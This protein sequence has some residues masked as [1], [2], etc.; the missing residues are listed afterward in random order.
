MRP[1]VAASPRDRR[2]ARRTFPFIAALALLATLALSAVV[3]AEPGDEPF[4]IERAPA[5]EW[6]FKQSW[7]SYAPQPAVTRGASVVAG[8]E[9]APYQLGWAFESGSYDSAS[10]TTVLR[11]EG[12]AHWLKYP[13][14]SSSI[15]PPPGYSG[16]MDIHVLDVTLSDPV[17]TISRD[18][19]TITVEASSRQLGTWQIEDLGRVPVVSLDVSEAAPAVADGVTTWTAIPAVS[20]GSSNE[21]FAGNYPAGRAVD[22]VGFSYSGP[23]GAPDLSE[24][25]DAPGSTKLAL[26]DN[27]I[28]TEDGIA[29]QFSAWWLDRERRIVHHRSA[30]TVDGAPV[31][32]YRALSLD[33]RAPVG[34]PLVLPNAESIFQ[35]TFFDSDGGRLFYRRSGET[36]TSRWVEFDAGQG[37]YVLGTLSEPV[38]IVGS[39]SLNWDSVA[40][41]A[42]NV[43]RFVPDGVAA[44]AYDSHQW[45]LNTYSEQDDGTWLRKTYELPSLPTGL[46]AL[47][48]STSTSVNAPS[49]V[50][51]PDGSLILLGDRQSRSTPD[52]TVP[53]TVPGAYR[54]VFDEAGDAVSVAPVAGTEVGNGALTVFKALQAGPGG[55][56]TLM[57]AANATG[58]VVQDVT[59]AGGE[60]SA[61]PA[62]TVAGLDTL[63]TTDFAVDPVD[64]TVW[65]G[66]WQSQRIVGIRGGEVVADQYFPE[67]HPRGGPLLVGPDHAVYAQTNDGSPAVVGGSPV[68][69]FG[70]FARLG[71]SPRVTGQP[72]SATATLASGEDSEAVAFASTATGDPAPDRRWQ[73][74]RPGSS[75]FAEVEGESGPTLTVDAVRGLGGAEVRAVYS[76]AAGAIASEPATLAVDYAPEIAVD[77][78]DVGVVEG[79][80]A[81]FQVLSQGSPDPAVAW[82]RRVAGFWQPIAADDE[83]FE[84][85]DGTLT[86]TE[87]H[88]DQSGAQFRARVGNSVA[89]IYSRAARLTVEPATTIPPGGLSLDGV[90]LDWSGSDELQRLAPNMQ[91]SFLSAGVSDGGEATYSAAAANAR[92]LHV[93]GDGSE[94]PAT[95]ATRAA[96]AGA[97]VDQLVRLTDGHA[98]V[99]QDGSATVTWPGSF[100][101][102]FYGGLVP[103]TVSRPELTVDADGG[104]TLRADLSGY[105]ASMAD[106][107]DRHPVAPVDDVVVATFDG[108][109][110]DPQGVVT[111]EPDYAGIEVEAPAGFAAQDRASAGWGAWP[112]PFVDFHAAT[113]LAPYWYSS[114]GVFDAHKAASPF[115]VDF[116]GAGSVPPLGP[117]GDG[118]VLAPPP[119]P[120]PRVSV[121]ALAVDRT[122]YGRAARATVRVA[123]VGGAAPGGGVTVRVA[124]RAVGG[125]LAGGV[126]RLRLP[127]DLRPGAHRVTADYAGTAGVAGSAAT[128]TLRVLRAKPRVGLRVVRGRDGRP[129]R[130][131]V[132]ARF[133]GA[134]GLHPTGQ[135]V[136]RDRGRVVRVVRLRRS[137]AGRRTI[138]LPRL[139]AGPHLL[140]VAL[141]AGP[142]Q[143]AAASGFR[144]VRAGR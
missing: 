39:Q 59:V 139:A 31:W 106:P 6:G 91:P 89:T 73:I 117:G 38:P 22:A 131:S 47:G 93:A 127:A 63:N 118:D 64:G 66:G 67:R 105:G 137:D 80:Q 29:S 45:Q 26:E 74:K 49:G 126:A 122:S 132:A 68:Y 65:V 69:G 4:A 98:E 101:V 70:R 112:Q 32:V 10:G 120:S 13:A 119:P 103:F 140:R 21:V 90:S 110:I 95:W 14:A 86:V 116:T 113:G 88:V 62:V 129:R 56:V 28:L 55:Q 81:T 60:A 33:T 75:R 97:A 82:Q 61:A 135:L 1:P 138:R 52:V 46:N 144:A 44:N 141:A 42:F 125:T 71:F 96:Q 16:P 123:A 99:E 85:G 43:R 107:G 124:G 30:A 27:E 136:V 48:Y 23:G 130:L 7:R 109:E 134:A 41:R 25:W 12:T 104:G 2:V 92:V 77:V 76:N 79:E 87:T 121:T 20:D 3:A 128:A 58:P 17:L 37:R 84:I 53:A 143:R 11:Y 111:F 18:E 50:A 83:G 15:A 72:E 51:A 40:K 5:L 114:G 100:S 35:P 9:G 115:S 57:R 102:N 24:H 8:A 108:A 54:I 36:E 34:E 133:P 78:A 94:T 19:A 142:L